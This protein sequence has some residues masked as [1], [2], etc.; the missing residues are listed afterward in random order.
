MERTGKE[1]GGLEEGGRDE[2]REIAVTSPGGLPVW[3]N[4]S[5]VQGTSPLIGSLS[6]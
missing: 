3:E 5:T 1:G 2:S 4:S 6:C